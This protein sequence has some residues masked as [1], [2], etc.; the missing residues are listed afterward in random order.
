MLTDE[1]LPME[2]SSVSVLRL[3]DM[4]FI[5]ATCDCGRQES[6]SVVAFLVVNEQQGG[7]FWKQRLYSSAVSFLLVS[8]PSKMGYLLSTTAQLSVP[9][10]K[11]R[12]IPGSSLT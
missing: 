8:C 6:S 7:I 1:K 11:S 4:V 2:K 5:Y 12:M 3:L 9:L 10:A